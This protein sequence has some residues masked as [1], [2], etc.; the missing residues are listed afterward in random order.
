MRP[1]NLDVLKSKQVI[2]FDLDGTLADSKLPITPNMAKLLRQ[3]LRQRVVGVISGADFDSFKEQLI[4]RLGASEAE[5]ANLHILPTN[6]TRYLRYDLDTNTWKEIYSDEIPSQ[7]RKKIAQ[8][9]EQTARKLG[10]WE[11]KV[12]GEIIEDRQSQVTFSGLG[13]SAPIEAKKAWDPDGSKR[14]RLRD[15]VARLLPNYAVHTAGTTSVDVTQAGLDKANEITKIKEVL[16]VEQREIIYVGD[17]L[18]PGGNDKVVKD[19]GFDVIAV[20]GPGDTEKIIKELLALEE[21]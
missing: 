7:Q 4:D 13:Q 17:A 12:W 11:T 16:G 10:L 14:K 8:I 5:L 15:E 3:L 19:A 20:K 1:M 9:L 6:G 18:A 2:V 21:G